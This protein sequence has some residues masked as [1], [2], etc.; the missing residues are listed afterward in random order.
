MDV[1]V[2]RDLPGRNACVTRV[3]KDGN[4]GLERCRD[5]IAQWA[6][7]R[8]SA[9]CRVSRTSANDRTWMSGLDRSEA[10]AEASRAKA[11]KVFAAALRC[12]VPASHKPWVT[13]PGHPSNTCVRPMD[14]FTGAPSQRPE[15][16]VT[17]HAR[18]GK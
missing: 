7:H 8:L 9:R 11:Q 17:S 12:A 15:K 3:A 2:E 16:Q 4:P 10:G 6:N 5:C 18:N 1:Y 14:G 13:V